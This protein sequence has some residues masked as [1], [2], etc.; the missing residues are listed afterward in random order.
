MSIPIDLERRAA[1][2]RTTAGTVQDGTSGG[3][4]QR[5]KAPVAGVAAHHDIGV[6]ALLEVRIEDRFAGRAPARLPLQQVDAME[7]TGF[8]HQP[9]CA[10]I[11]PVGAQARV[12]GAGFAPDLHE[13]RY[14]GL[15]V[16]RK[17]A[18]AVPQVPAAA[19]DR[20][21]SSG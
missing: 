19:L 3:R 1:H 4:E 15:V 5:V 17:P 8:A 14:P 2:T 11:F 18:S 6:A 9:P 21:R 16:A 13:A 12:E 20:R 7:V 10:A